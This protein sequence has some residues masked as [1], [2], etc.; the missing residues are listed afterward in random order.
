MSHRRRRGLRRRVG[1]KETARNA[2]IGRPLTASD[3]DS[4]PLYSSEARR[5]VL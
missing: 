3:D 5:A 4:D 2:A 1:T